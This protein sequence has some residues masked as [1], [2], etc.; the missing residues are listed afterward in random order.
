MKPWTTWLARLGIAGA[1]LLVTGCGGSD[2]PDAS[3]EGQAATESAPDA[4]GARAA[5][6]AAA[7]IE[8]EKVAQADEAPKAEEAAAEPATPAPAPETEP[9]ADSPKPPE[10][11]GSSS[12]AE[13]LAMATGP[14]S[15]GADAAPGGST[16]PAGRSR[17]PGAD[18]AGQH[19]SGWWRRAAAARRHD[20]RRAGAHGYDARHGSRSGPQPGMPGGPGMPRMPGMGP[21]HGRPGGPGGAR[22]PGM[23][24]PGMPG[25]GGPGAD[26]K[27][28]DFHSPEGAVK[29]FLAA[30]KA[31][32]LDRLNEA[33]AL[34][35]Q[36]EAGSSKSQELFKKIF[37]LS[38]SDSEL[39]QLAEALDWLHH[40]GRKSPQEHGQGRGHSA[41]GR[42][43]RRLL[44]FE[45]SRY[46]TKRKGGASWMSPARC[47]LSPMGVI[48]RNTGTGGAGGGRR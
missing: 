14:S 12:T 38:L 16:P 18:D 47:N 23:G 43:E 27:P 33:T 20:A 17:R 29:A 8:G 4:G 32:D 10:G 36:V 37:D 11:K 46:A 7:P 39:D 48:R 19:G 30:L 31:K 26:N 24:G 28:P 3:N 34:R 5:A 6:P 42:K 13:M 15:G 45:R 40:L 44:P 22:G 35:A 2:V 41:K 21:A 25:M 1:C 9:P